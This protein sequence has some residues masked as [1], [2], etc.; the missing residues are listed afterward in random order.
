MVYELGRGLAFV[1]DEHIALFVATGL[2]RAGYE[3]VSIREAGRLGLSDE[4]HIAWAYENDLVIV[5][6]DDDFLALAARGYAHK[7]IV[8]ANPARFMGRPA[9]LLTA[10]LASADTIRA[11]SNRSGIHFI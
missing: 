4:S 10:L 11:V 2:R 8:F 7:G 3:A 6:I 9:A 5:T 1:T